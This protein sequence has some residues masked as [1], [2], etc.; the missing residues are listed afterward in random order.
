MLGIK[1]IDHVSVA[2]GDLEDRV[3]FYKELFAMQEVERFDM[4]ADGFKGATLSIPGSPTRW[5]VLTPV[6]EDSF[7]HTF[8]AG[9]GPGVHHVTF[10]VEDAAKAA[11]AL[12]AHGI[13]PLNERTVHGWHE[14]FIHPKDSGGVLIQLYEIVGETT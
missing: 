5:E 4:S 3:R 1:R 2:T 7:L 10:Q 11:D 6:G 13:E 8:L 9:R 12:R 14:M